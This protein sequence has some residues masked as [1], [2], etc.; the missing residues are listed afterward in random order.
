M[1]KIVNIF[2]IISLIAVLSLVLIEILWNGKSQRMSFIFLWSAG[3]LFVF[4]IPLVFRSFSLVAK[5]D[6]I[7]PKTWL[8]IYGCAVLVYIVIAVMLGFINMTR[9]LPLA[10]REDYVSVEGEARVLDEKSNK[11]IVASQEFT[12]E[13]GKFN[14]AKPNESYRIIYLPNSKYVIDVINENGKSLLKK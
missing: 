10:I 3:V 6:K 1:K 13:N 8:V 14:K 2:S 5:M 12:L 7:N 11:I 9:D 4:V